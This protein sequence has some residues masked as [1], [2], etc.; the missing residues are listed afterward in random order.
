MEWE[1]MGK[2]RDW[3]RCEV[4]MG[5]GIEW[6]FVWGV[7]G[8]HWE[9]GMRRCEGKGRR[10]GRC[11]RCPTFGLI[12]ATSQALPAKYHLAASVFA[13]LMIWMR[14]AVIDDAMH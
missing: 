12:G 5:F 1:E 11:V 4:G 13:L 7:G 2:C 3:R 10:D 14:T 9:A 8:S 6:D